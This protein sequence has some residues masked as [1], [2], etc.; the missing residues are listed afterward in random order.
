[1]KIEV[2]SIFD[3]MD[4]KKRPVFSSCSGEAIG[5]TYEYAIIDGIKQLVPAGKTNR[6]D[7]INSFADETDINV[8]VAKFLN[9]DTSV[10]NDAVGQF[11]DFRNCPTT[12][13]EMFD[14]IQKCENLFNSMPIEVKEKFDFSYEKFWS[15]FGSN[16]FEDVFREY[17]T[18][19]EPV[20]SPDPSI[21]DKG[22]SDV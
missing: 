22:E 21:V 5:T 19:S 4:K 10:I 6:Q 11:G 2:S 20:P 8:I 17:N 12:Y 16:Y 18:S 1:M 9:G 15:E 13:A 7:F 14:R 3:K